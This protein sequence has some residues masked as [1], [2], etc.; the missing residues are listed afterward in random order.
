[1]K[2][3]WAETFPCGHLVLRERKKREKG[4]ERERQ[5]KWSEKWKKGEGSLPS[6]H[7]VLRFKFSFV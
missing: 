2:K 4:T 6:G 5:K 1:M 7:L 3:K